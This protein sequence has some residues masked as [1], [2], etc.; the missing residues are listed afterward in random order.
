MPFPGLPCLP[1]LQGH[2]QA[3]LSTLLGDGTFHLHPILGSSGQAI[4]GGVKGGRSGRGT[5][6]QAPFCRG[7]LSASSPDF[8]GLRTSRVTTLHQKGPRS[9]HCCRHVLGAVSP[10][11]LSLWVSVQQVC[12]RGLVSKVGCLCRL[13]GS[14]LVTLPSK[15]PGVFVQ[16]RSEA[17]GTAAPYPS[18]CAPLQPFQPEGPCICPGELRA[19]AHLC[20]A[21]TKTWTELGCVRQVSGYAGGGTST[22]WDRSQDGKGHAGLHTTQ[23][24][25]P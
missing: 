12:V 17:P 22:Q 14:V 21:R 8:Q 23:T 16:G 3:P 18:L 19:C 7:G 1:G 11:S 9:R 15:L 2:F 25:D 24:D 13:K 20:F 5:R 4:P 10:P 6:G